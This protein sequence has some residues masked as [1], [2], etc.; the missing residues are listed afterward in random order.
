[1]KDFAGIFAPAVH[2]AGRKGTGG[3]RVSIRSVEK[4]PA[5]QSA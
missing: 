5:Q 2:K 4:K 1:M 3:Y